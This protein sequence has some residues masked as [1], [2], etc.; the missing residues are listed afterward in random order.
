MLGCR[1]EEGNNGKIP[2]YL[3]LLGRILRGQAME[4]PC[5]ELCRSL[6]VSGGTRR[7]GLGWV[8]GIAWECC[9]AAP[10]LGVSKARLDEAWSN[11]G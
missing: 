7:G 11:L 6:L 9:V 10:S 5:A 8:V 3:L 1:L 4:C 2:D